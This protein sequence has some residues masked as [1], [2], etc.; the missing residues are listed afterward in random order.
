MTDDKQQAKDSPAGGF[1]GLLGSIIGLII[2][3][4]GAAVAVV[5]GLWAGYAAIAAAQ[6]SSNYP[7]PL[8]LVGGGIFVAIVIVCRWRS[9]A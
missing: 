7:W 5:G 3:E 1:G 2:R 9:H 8:Y 6:R 4:V